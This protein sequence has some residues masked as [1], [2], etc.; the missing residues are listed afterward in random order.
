MPDTTAAYIGI[1]EDKSNAVAGLVN[2]T[3]NIGSS[4][5]TSIVTTMNVRR[6]QF[7]QAVLVTSTNMGNPRF[8]NSM[9]GL[10]QQLAHAGLSLHEAQKTIPGSDLRGS[11]VPGSRSGVYRHLLGARHRG[12]HHVFLVLRF[13]EK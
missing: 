13:E 3:R 9:N 2:F 8:R 7:H 10:V 4:V 12:P 1:G 11:P 5:G 6:S